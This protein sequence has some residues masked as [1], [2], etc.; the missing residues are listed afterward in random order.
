MVENQGALA[1]LGG[2]A[3]ALALATRF[4]YNAPARADTLGG[5]A[6]L[7]RFSETISDAANPA[8]RSGLPDALF[9]F[10]KEPQ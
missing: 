1:T 9:T 5:N 6:G 4:P 8:G 7:L 10:W 3:R 2:P